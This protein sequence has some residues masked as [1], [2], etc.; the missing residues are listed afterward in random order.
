MASDAN[1]EL[2]LNE[3]D[4]LKKSLELLTSSS[5][6]IMTCEYVRLYAD[7]IDDLV[8]EE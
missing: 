2:W 4:E 8:D 5:T 6:G 3:F 7:S 1:G